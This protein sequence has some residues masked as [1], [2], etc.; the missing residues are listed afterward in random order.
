VT[1]TGYFAGDVG[2]GTTTP[3]SIFS[4]QGVRNWTD[5]MLLDGLAR[6]RRKAPS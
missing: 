1:G 2:I 6:G 5:V 4:I 3:G